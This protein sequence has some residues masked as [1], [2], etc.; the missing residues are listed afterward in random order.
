MFGFLKKK[1]NNI[2]CKTETDKNKITI[3]RFQRYST[4]VKNNCMGYDSVQCAKVFI[5]IMV[6][7]LNY[8]EA[9]QALEKEH[10]AQNNSLI[11]EIYSKIESYLFL[12]RKTILIEKEPIK[13]DIN[14]LPILLNPWNGERILNNFISINDNNV[15]DGVRFSWNIQNHY[16]YPMNIIVCTGGNHSQ[17]SARYQNKGETVINE[18]K[19]FTSL[20]DK[21][22]FD[23]ANYIIKEDNTIIEMEYDENILFYSGVIFEL[24]RYLLGRN[25]SNSDYIGSYLN[26]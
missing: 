25:Y 24:G 16:L 21:V 7:H 11:E 13:I 26:L 22:K 3:D 20:Y 6:E 19:D 15:F 9:L 18:I 17:L 4:L 2:I 1:K 14:K 12:N 8:E 10:G 5:E 23:G